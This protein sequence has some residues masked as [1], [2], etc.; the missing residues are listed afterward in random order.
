MEEALDRI[1]KV[2]KGEQSNI[3]IPS[4][5]CVAH[6]N[7]NKFKDRYEED[8]CKLI[9]IPPKMNN[10]DGKQFVMSLVNIILYHTGRT[11]IVIKSTEQEWNVVST[12]F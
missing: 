2:V 7:I 10:N 1:L 9:R 11:N 6:Q 5:R 8:F 12:T 3:D 4:C